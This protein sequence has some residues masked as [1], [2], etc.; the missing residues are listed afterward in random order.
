MNKIIS[1]GEHMETQ[2]A[3]F[4]RRLGA[5]L[6]DG[7][8]VG[9]PFVIISV[10]VAICAIGAPAGP[11]VNPSGVGG[12]QAELGFGAIFCLVIA[13]AQ[14]GESMATGTLGLLFLPRLISGQWYLR[15][16]LLVVSLSVA[17]LLLPWL[18]QAIMESSSKQATLGKMLL[19]IKVT[20]LDG[21]RI[22]FWKATA[23][24]FSKILSTLTLLAGYLMAGW[25]NKKQA[26]HDK[27]AGC[28]VVVRR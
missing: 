20:D 23:R 15:P 7:V 11:V 3:G 28:L 14:A 6:I 12:P 2:Y 18:Y 10:I 1:Q 24:H 17:F 8:V 25:T 4:W 27:I 9:S 13:I 16:L 5:A 22:S 26:L 21:Q 19:K